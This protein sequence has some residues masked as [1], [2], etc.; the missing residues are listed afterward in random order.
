VKEKFLFICEENIKR[1]G[2]NDLIAWLTESDFF[3]APASTKYHGSF[4]GGLLEHS[5]N[6]YECLKRSIQFHE[7]NETYD[8]ETIA[9]VSLFHDVCKVNF[10]AKSIRN[11]KDNGKWVETEVFE[12]NEKFPCGDHS[13]KSV[14]L[15]QQF[16]KLKPDEILA[17]RAHMGA[18][19]NAAKG[20]GYFIGRIF[21]RCKLAVLLHLADM[22]A[23]YMLEE[24]PK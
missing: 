16:L 3:T 15:I 23:T 1:D 21:E 2:V 8:N 17:I 6:V 24:R 10:Y 22:E 12:T 13:D 9:I 5:L 18:W 19:D 20:G 11:V 14:I 4:E 7:L